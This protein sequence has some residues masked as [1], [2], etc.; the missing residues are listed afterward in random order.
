[1]FYRTVK[2]LILTGM[3]GFISNL[4]VNAEEVNAEEKSI[5]YIAEEKVP[6]YDETYK[7]EIDIL[8]LGD[9]ITLLSSYENGHYAMESEKGVYGYIQGHF[10]QNVKHNS[11]YRA[12]MMDEEGNSQFGYI[13]GEISSYNRDTREYV[14]SCFDGTTLQVSSDEDIYGILN[15]FV[16][17]YQKEDDGTNQVISLEGENFWTYEFGYLGIIPNDAVSVTGEIVELYRDAG[18]FE[19]TNYNYSDL[20][21]LKNSEGENEFFTTYYNA[22]RYSDEHGIGTMSTLETLYTGQKIIAMIDPKYK[23]AYF[24]DSVE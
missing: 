20:I 15:D 13:R 11:I 21:L 7:N 10:N 16:C 9:K 6:V 23:I 5:F 3:V 18:F 24:Y 19:K 8:N 14:I 1:M 17:W 12:D 22:Y 4:T 2:L